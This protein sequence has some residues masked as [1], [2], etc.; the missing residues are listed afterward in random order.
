VLGRK[1]WNHLSIEL[2][3]D[4]FDHLPGEVDEILTRLAA[5]G[6]PTGPP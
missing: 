5:G 4:D 1:N 6:T 3:L 2:H